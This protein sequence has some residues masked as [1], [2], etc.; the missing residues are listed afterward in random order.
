MTPG[1]APGSQPPQRGFIAPVI[2]IRIQGE[3][4]GL[5]KPASAAPP[6]VVEAEKPPAQP[7]PK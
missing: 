2:D 4:I 1:T 5:P 3:G 6:P 7:A